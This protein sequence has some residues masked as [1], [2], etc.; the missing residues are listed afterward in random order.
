MTC[1]S[2]GLEAA[3]RT[4]ASPSGNRIVLSTRDF[5]WTMNGPTQTATHAE[6]ASA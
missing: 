4:L 6:R 5:G 2:S 3:D 1:P